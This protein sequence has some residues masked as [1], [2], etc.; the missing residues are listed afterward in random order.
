MDVAK[1]KTM[2]DMGSGMGKIAIQVSF[3]NSQLLDAQHF[4]LLLCK[5]FHQFGQLRKVTGVEFTASRAQHGFAAL[6]KLSQMPGFKGVYE[7]T[8]GKGTSQ[9]GANT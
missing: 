9:S 8:E 5:A 2:S 3:G 4:L 1:A 6:R 7:L